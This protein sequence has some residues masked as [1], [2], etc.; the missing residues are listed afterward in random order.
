M[1][2]STINPYRVVEVLVG[3]SEKVMNEFAAEGYRVFSVTIVT[4]PKNDF[5]NDPMM[6]ITFV[7]LGVLS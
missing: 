3:G 4:Y 2:H 5:E 6:V 7:K 1:T